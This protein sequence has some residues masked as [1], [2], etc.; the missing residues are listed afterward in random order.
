MMNNEFSMLGQ[1]EQA[2]TFGA[3][4]IQAQPLTGFTAQQGFEIQQTGWTSL[5][6]EL[7]GEKSALLEKIAEMRKNWGELEPD[8]EKQVQGLY[9]KMINDSAW[10]N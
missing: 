3:E 10:N 1:F 5:P 7:D 8:I 9:D 6:T 2:K 4:T